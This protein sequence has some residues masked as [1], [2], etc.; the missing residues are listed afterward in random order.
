M[1]LLPLIHSRVDISASVHNTGTPLDLA[2]DGPYDRGVDKGSTT[3]IPIVNLFQDV[4]TGYSEIGVKK[5][6]T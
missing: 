3:D 4:A 1:S 6:E 5:P 2:M